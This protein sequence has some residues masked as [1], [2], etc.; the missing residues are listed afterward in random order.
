[1]YNHLYS[2]YEKLQTR[3]GVERGRDTKWD[4]LIQVYNLTQ[5]LDLSNHD[6]SNPIP[7][8]KSKRQ[9]KN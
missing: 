2:A 3:K 4:K 1:M 6:G 9:Q 5:I 8:K 7:L